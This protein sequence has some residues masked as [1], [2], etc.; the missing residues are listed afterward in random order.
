MDLPSLETYLSYREYLRDYFTA[1]KEADPK[2]SHRFFAQRAGFTSTALVPLLIQGKRNLTPLYMD[3]FIR[4]LGLDLRLASYFRTLVEFTHAKTDQE[5]IALENELRKFRVKGPTRVETASLRFYESWV[6]VAL[7]QALS[8]LDVKT[9]L[10]PVR[11]FLEPKPSLDELRRSLQLLRELELV[12]KDKNGFWKPSEQNLLADVSIGPWV[13]RAFRNQMMD[14]GRN[15]HDR[16]AAG[17]SKHVT[18]T[19]ALSSEAAGR[20]RKRLEA[21]RQEAVA[22]ALSDALPAREL[23]QLNIQLFP[24]SGDS[25]A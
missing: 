14:L 24:L 11:D 4:A 21:F 10:A 7:H 25:T 6:N 17:R 2:F 16:F 1:R 13:I 23:L 19:L 8:C 5:R 22:I 12:R 9:D 15:A 20:I 3:G 18:E